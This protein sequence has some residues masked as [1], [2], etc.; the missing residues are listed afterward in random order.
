MPGTFLP[1]IPAANDIIAF[2][3]GQLQNNFQ[4]L[5]AI[6]GNGTAAGVSYSINNSAGFNWLY[7]PPQ[8][9]IPPAAAGFPTSNIG[10]YSANSTITGKNELFI[11]KTNQATV[12]QVS[13]TGSILSNVS[14]PAY[15]SSGWS[16]LPS[17]L[18]IKWGFQAG[19]LTP[20]PHT[21]NFISGPNVPVFSQ[22]FT[23]YITEVH[24]VNS[25]FDHVI[26][27]NS[28]TTT[29]YKISCSNN[30]PAACGITYLAVG[31]PGSSY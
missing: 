24:D 23:V 2:S 25:P 12:T 11:N 29:T 9:T 6:A 10:L 1:N 27:L 14:A 22:V 8:G 4:V 7:L 19:P 28:W 15:Q 13:A 20:L 3:Q 21:F 16:Y 5:G 30:T 26:A 31:I 17:G 18:L